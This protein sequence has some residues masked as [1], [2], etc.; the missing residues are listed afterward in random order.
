MLAMPLRDLFGVDV[1]QNHRQLSRADPLRDARAHDA[2]ADDRRARHRLSV[3]R[4]KRP[5]NV[6][7]RARSCRKKTLIKLRQASVCIS[8]M[9]PSRS[10]ASEA[11]TDPRN[12]A[13][14]DFQRFQHGG[15]MSARFFQ[16]L[17][18]NLRRNQPPPTSGLFVS[19]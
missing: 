9:M 14:H 7:F 10:S 18:A 16:K 5:G 17:L 15:I 11:A 1:A 13:R 8:S 12:A 19:Q 4:L 6:F 3:R 2:R